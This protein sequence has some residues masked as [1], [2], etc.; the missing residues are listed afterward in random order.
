MEGILEKAIANL[1]NELPGEANTGE[2]LARVQ[3]IPM[4]DMEY[5]RLWM[6]KELVTTSRQT[7]RRILRTKQMSICL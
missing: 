2:L 3:E 7:L 1:Q 6:L 5:T 4:E